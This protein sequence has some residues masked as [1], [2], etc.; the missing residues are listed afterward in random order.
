VVI[1][2]KPWDVESVALEVRGVV[3]GKVVVSVAAGVKLAM[4]S[5]LLPG[6]IVYRAMPN[7]GVEIGLSLTALAE[8]R[9][10]E[11]DM[12]VE[13]L[14]RCVGEVFWVKE[15]LIPAWTGIAGSGPGLLASIGDAILL[16]AVAAGIPAEQA[17]RMVAKLLEA[18]GRLVE[19]YGLSGLRNA[20]ATPGGTTIAGL[21]LLEKGARG[22]VL[23]AFLAAVRRAVEL[24][25]KFEH[26]A[27]AGGPND[28]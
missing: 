11:H 9:G 7:L 23:E 1:S 8:K 10:S 20:V 28:S 2:V 12:M 3:E 5:R 17:E 16:A 24:E 14:F 21:S 26:D 19:R 22:G 27:G 4:L 25:N 6:A 15:E 18:T 13:N